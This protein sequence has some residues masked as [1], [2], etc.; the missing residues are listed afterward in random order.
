MATVWEAIQGQEQLKRKLQ[1]EMALL[2][3]L[4][5]MG[6]PNDA[7]VRVV[8]QTERSIS[9]CD[10]RVGRLVKLRRLLRKDH[11]FESPKRTHRT[12]KCSVKIVDQR[13]LAICVDGVPSQSADLPTDVLLAAIN[14]E[15]GGREKAHRLQMAFGEGRVTIKFNL[16]EEECE[17]HYKD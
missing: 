15:S 8:S 5:M 1:V 9:E 14:G 3:D 4:N 10:S 11:V 6:V 17:V 2:R 13:R 7:L 12:S 16:N